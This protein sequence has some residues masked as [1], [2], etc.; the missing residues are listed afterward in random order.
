RGEIP[1]L[2]HEQACRSGV[3]RRHERALA[4]RRELARAELRTERAL[5]ETQRRVHHLDAA[6]VRV[7]TDSRADLG[8]FELDVLVIVDAE[9]ELD[10]R[11]TPQSQALRADVDPGLREVDPRASVGE[12]VMRIRVVAVRILGVNVARNAVAAFQTA[13]GDA[14]RP[15]LADPGCACS[16][17]ARREIA[18]SDDAGSLLVVMMAEPRSVRHL[19]VVGRASRAVEVPRERIRRAV[20]PYGSRSRPGPRVAAHLDERVVPLLHR[21]RDPIGD[22]VDDAAD[23]AAAVQQRRRSAKD[24]DLLRSERIEADRVI[25]ADARGVERIDAVLEDFDARTGETADHRPGR[26]GAEIGRADAEL[27]GQR[28]AE[29]IPEPAAQRVPGKYTDRLRRLGR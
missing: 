24:L 5:P 27:V 6:F 12:T 13:H 18:V 11:E 26:A 10:F 14:E 3:R 23:R 29:R 1:V 28:L 16:R 7:V 20:E 8:V 4:D 22:R 15:A 19:V 17:A 25:D 2:E 9:R 21:S